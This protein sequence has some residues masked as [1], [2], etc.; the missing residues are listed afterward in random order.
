MSDN[1][2]AYFSLKFSMLD[3]VNLINPEH[4]KVQKA[5]PA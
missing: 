2:K 3:V 5:C 1:S 4:P